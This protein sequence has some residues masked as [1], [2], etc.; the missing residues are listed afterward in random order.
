MI[1]LDPVIPMHTPK[2]HGYAYFVTD[3]GFDHD[4]LWTVFLDT[5]EIWSFRNREVRA[6]ENYTFGRR[7]LR[8]LQREKRR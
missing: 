2:G 1:Q 3:S 5:G 6:V 8:K 7:D 4:L